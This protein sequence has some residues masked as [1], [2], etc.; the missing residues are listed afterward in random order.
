M[1]DGFKLDNGPSWTHI[2]FTLIHRRTVTAVATRHVVS[3]SRCDAALQR[4]DL[5][6]GGCGR[7]HETRNRAPSR[8]GWKSHRPV[9]VHAHGATGGEARALRVRPAPSDF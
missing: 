1:F 5:F 9:R 2:N 8:P 4:R 6:R 7:C 3:P